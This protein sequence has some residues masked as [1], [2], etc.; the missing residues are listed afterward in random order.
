[1]LKKSII[2]LL[3]ISIIS[4]FS[5]A[6]GENANTICESHI[7]MDYDS[8]TVLDGKEIHKPQFPASTTKVMTAILALELGNL[9]D[10][11]TVDQEVVDLTEGSH[12]ALEPGEEMALGEML[13]ALLVSSANDSALAIAKHI[14]GSIDEFVALM[15]EK[16]KEIGADNTNF[17]NPHGLHDEE[18]VTTAYDLALIAHYAMENETFR[19][20]V[21][22]TEYTIEATEVKGE[23]RYLFTT[24]K[25][26]RSSQN[27][28]YDGKMAPITY[29]GAQGVKTGYTEKASNCLV[30]YAERDG[31]RLLAV[32]L[33]SQSTGVYLDTHKLLDYGFDNFQSIKIGSKNEFIG[34]IDIPN[35][36][37]PQVSGVLE[38]DI[39]QPL[40]NLD[41]DTL[42]KKVNLRSNLKAPIK[43]GEI[44]GTMEYYKDGEVIAEGNILSTM[45]VE[46][47]PSGSITSILINRWYI[48]AIILLVVLRVVFLSNRRRRKKRRRS[49]SLYV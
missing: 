34:N 48:V 2:I 16:A 20:Y 28:E 10:I 13:Y 12:I 33:K 45:G 31:Q 27:I 37:I 5:L 29:E 14:S 32:V 23:P 26:L 11:V 1:M 3:I 44:I 19:N 43:E 24:N 41:V 25:L 21:N 39:L 36:N 4:S 42:D 35:G 6:Y 47:T 17:V 8:M 49:K 22:T 40:S 46:A 9:D 7:L 15:N 38:N 30:S 18:H